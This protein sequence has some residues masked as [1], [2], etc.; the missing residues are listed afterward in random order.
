MELRVLLNLVSGPAAIPAADALVRAVGPTRE[1]GGRAAD[2]DDDLR[3]EALEFAARVYAFE[4]LPGKATQLLD[5][6]PETAAT[7]RCRAIVLG[8]QGHHDR[9]EQV[10]IRALDL[11]DSTSQQARLAN[12]VG[13]AIAR[14]GRHD[15]AL[16]WFQR[17]LELLEPPQHFVPYGNMAMSQLVL[18]RFA[19]AL[20]SARAA[21]RIAQHRGARRVAVSA[22]VYG[23]AAVRADEAEL[24]HIAD[25]A[26]FSLKRYGI[27]DPDLLVSVL[28]QARPT[29][30]AGRDFVQAMLFAFDGLSA[31]QGEPG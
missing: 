5:V 14:A 1:A 18:G 15:E 7:L 19:Q 26:L 11:A 20:E 6:L 31:R 2:V 10:L 24:I 27:G 4:S 16:T 29:T 28:Q 23:V 25:Q 22:I 30:Q 13:N 8:E 9:A 12:S 17:T 3:Q 21:F